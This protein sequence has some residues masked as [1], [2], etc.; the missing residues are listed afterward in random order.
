MDSVALQALMGIICIYVLMVGSERSAAA[1]RSCH[2]AFLE[3]WFRGARVTCIQTH[4]PCMT[5]RC[6]SVCSVGPSVLAGAAY[7]RHLSYQLIYVPTLRLS[8]RSL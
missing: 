5:V 3:V 1:A 6:L 7:F 2:T 4:T 8:I